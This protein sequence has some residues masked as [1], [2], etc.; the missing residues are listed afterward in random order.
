[1]TLLVIPSPYLLALFSRKQIVVLLI[2]QYL[3]VCV[4][5]CACAC[6]RVCGVCVC[7]CG[8]CVCVCGGCVC[9][10]VCACVC[11]CVPISA[12]ARHNETIRKLRHWPASQSDILQSLK[13]TWRMRELVRRHRH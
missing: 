4:R 2:L 3:C 5:V 13:A 1:M 10:R 12:F 6:V 7:V 9:A 8:V 11:V